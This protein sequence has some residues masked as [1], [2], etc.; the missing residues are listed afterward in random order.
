M[1]RSDNKK[2]SLDG[3]NFYIY[4]FGAMRASKIS[5]DLIGFASPLIAAIISLVGGNESDDAIGSVLDMDIA[6][7]SKF[8]IPA[9]RGINGDD[10]E[11][12]LRLLLIK[13]QNISYDTDDDRACNWLDENALDEIFVCRLQDMYMLAWEVIKMNFGGFF[14]LLSSQS[15]SQEGL[16]GVVSKLRNTES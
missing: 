4:P 8:V 1:K 15:G 2:V 7:A 11:K 16:L 6:D 3:Y 14:E 5:G 10:V 12:L 13:Y 9:F